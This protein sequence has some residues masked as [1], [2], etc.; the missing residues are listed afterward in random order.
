[1]KRTILFIVFLISTFYLLA[2]DVITRKNGEKIHC[3]ITKT[4]S[5]N[6]YFTI[7]KDHEDRDT[8]INRTEVADI[9]YGNKKAPSYIVSDK[10]LV[11]NK[12]KMKFDKYRLSFS[13]GCSF[14][15]GDFGDTNINNDAA[16]LAS[17]GSNFNFY[18]TEKFNPYFG[19]GMKLYYNAN[20]LEAKSITDELRMRTGVNWVSNTSYWYS[21][22]VLL[23]IIG[24]IPVD[25]VDF[26]FSIL[27]GT[28]SLSSPAA[29]FTAL[30][31]NFWA[32]LESSTG[33]AYG[34]NFGVGLNYHFSDK[35][36]LLANL[37]YFSAKVVINSMTL[38]FSDGTSQT[39]GGGYQ[40]FSVSN[41]TLG[42]GY[43]FR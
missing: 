36:S 33:D 41:L 7:Y 30:G 15:T 8:Y 1:M 23:G 19:I 29:R 32:Q 28:L 11:S 5:T 17:N 43:N 37:D 24:S 18:F 31:P 22:G 16:G 6:I 13:G 3:T 27:G 39:D 20:Q 42:L 14:A 26:E 9:K 34:Y 12:D 10:D 4:D 35:W 21:G 40:N 38:T 25:K 2:E